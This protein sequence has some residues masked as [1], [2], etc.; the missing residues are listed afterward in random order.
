MPR[1]LLKTAEVTQR[2]G[3]PEATMRYYRHRGIGPR[4]V[5]IGRTVDDDEAEL[6][7]WVESFFD[8]PERVD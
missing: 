5:R 2:A 3:K 8:D 4:S 6:D 7:A 1:K